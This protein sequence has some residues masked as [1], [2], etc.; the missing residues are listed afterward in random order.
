MTILAAIR[1]LQSL[2]DQLS[3]LELY[4]RQEC[5]EITI[6][7]QSIRMTRGAKTLT[8][9]LAQIPGRAM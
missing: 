2:N 9:P 6:S 1:A 4:D 5:D 3:A 8:V 7:E